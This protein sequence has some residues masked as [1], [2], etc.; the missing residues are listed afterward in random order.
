LLPSSVTF[1]APPKP[2]NVCTQMTHDIAEESSFHI[3]LHDENL[4]SPYTSCRQIY[5]WLRH[6]QPFSG[7]LVRC[8]FRVVSFKE[9]CANVPGRV[10]YTPCSSLIRSGLILLFKFSFSPDYECLVYS[11][12]VDRLCGLVVRVPGYRSRGPR[13]DSRRYQIF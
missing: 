4:K 5:M 1:Y 2:W 6:S 13:F 10:I 7:K 3:H 9:Q 8:S 11:Y 12:S